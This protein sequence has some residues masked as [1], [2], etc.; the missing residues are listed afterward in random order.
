MHSVN[1]IFCNQIH[2][3]HLKSFKLWGKSV[4][5]SI[6]GRDYPGGL[7]EKDPAPRSW[8]TAPEYKPFL[9]LFSKRPEYKSS[10]NG[11]D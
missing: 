4:D 10:K 9:E 1:L 7:M 5:N 3:I 2:R 8:L 6:A 11:E